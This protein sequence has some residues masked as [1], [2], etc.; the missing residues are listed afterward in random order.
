MFAFTSFP[1]RRSVYFFPPI[2]SFH[3]VRRFPF[4]FVAQFQSVCH[5]AVDG[6]DPRAF[7]HILLK[8]FSVTRGLVYCCTRSYISLPV[9][10]RAPTCPTCHVS[11]LAF[12]LRLSIS[13][14]TFVLVFV[15]L[16]ICLC[17]VYLAT[18]H[19]LSHPQ[20]CIHC[21]LPC[22][23][24]LRLFFSF[25]QLL[26]VCVCQFC[27]LSKMCPVYLCVQLS[28][29]S[30]VQLCIHCVRLCHFCIPL[31]FSLFQ[32]PHV[33]VRHSG[34]RSEMCTFS[35]L[36]ILVFCTSKCLRLFLHYY[37][38]RHLFLDILLSLNSL[39][40][41]FYRFIY[42]FLCTSQP[43]NLLVLNSRI[44]VFCHNHFSIFVESFILSLNSGLKSIYIRKE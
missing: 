20:P 29:P 21:V 1:S 42:S 35:C 23:Y 14:F 36:S 7:V 16:F 24:R 31:S 32:L 13:L 5:L 4:A 17:P 10:L 39:G 28:Y 41:H 6:I 37:S 15:H 40:L 18:S 25:F 26:H 22:H 3:S 34:Y 2:I 8:V 19:Y 12:I 44:S 11:N 33:C 38:L 43:V 27:Y 9:Y 30:R